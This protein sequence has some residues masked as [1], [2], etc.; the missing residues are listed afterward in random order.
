MPEAGGVYDVAIV[1][2]GPTGAT[3]ANLLG[4]CGVRVAVL[5]REKSLVLQPRAVHFDGEVMRVFQA[6]GLAD[7][8]VP[9]IRPSGGMRYVSPSG[10]VMVERKP[11]L[12]EGPHGWPNNY[13]FHQPDLENTLRAGVARFPNVE[14][15]AGVSVS[16]LTPAD[17]GVQLKTSASDVRARWVVGCDGARSIVRQAI[18]AEHEDLGLHQPW[19]VVDVVLERDLDL[20]YPTVQYCDP[21]RPVTVVNVTGRRRRWEIMLMPGDKPERLTEPETVWRLLAPW[22]RPGDA[23]LERSALYT[24][25]SL[26]ATRWR[27]GR[28][29]IAGDA[30]H[31]TPPF[32][33]QGMCTGIRDAANLAWKLARVLQGKSSERLLDSYESERAPHARQFIAEAVR[34]GG[35]LQTTDPQGRRRTRSALPRDWHRGDGEPLARAGPRGAR[36]NAAGGR[37]LSAAAPAGRTAAGRCDRRLPLRASRAVGP[38]FANGNFRGDPSSAR[39]RGAGAAAAGSL[40][41]GRKPLACPHSGSLRGALAMSSLARM[42]SILDLFGARAPVL[43]AEEIIAR[44]NYSRPTGY[45]Y[46]RE[47]VAAGLL[48]RAPGGYSLGPRIIELDWLDPPA[49]SRADGLA[50]SRP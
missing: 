42:L 9:V 41:R 26:V 25:H 15:F 23:R 49:R 47:L 1:G 3:L 10:V 8:L 22:I 31:Q 14:V 24:F 33:G 6:A 44:R 20:P 5:E 12:G 7:A 30:A 46:V 2:Y 32:L 48:V 35:I 4:A 37:N 11:A 39:Y 34:L 18:G 29:F 40:Y 45:R 36:R 16:A 21:A 19:L 43:S 50:R 17:D 27:K 38:S 13:L 28:L